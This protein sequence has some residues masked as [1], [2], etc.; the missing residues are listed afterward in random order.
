MSTLKIE[1]ELP[2]EIVEYL[3]TQEVEKSI[4]ELIILNFLRELKISQGKAKEI[5]EISKSELIELMRL[6][7][8]PAID[9]SSE[10][11]K[12]ELKRSEELLQA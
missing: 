11:L 6:H 4:K 10:E 9:L 7:S 2:E 8:I 1:L 12:E 3:G 5:L